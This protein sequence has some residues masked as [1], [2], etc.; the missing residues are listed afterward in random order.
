MDL[1]ER[2]ERREKTRNSP[3]TCEFSAAMPSQEGLLSLSFGRVGLRETI[4]A[5]NGRN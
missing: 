1:K 4:V 2:I 5:L 3:T